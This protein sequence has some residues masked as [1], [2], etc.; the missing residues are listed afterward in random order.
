MRVLSCFYRD[1][2]FFVNTVQEVPRHIDLFIYIYFLEAERK[3]MYNHK[4]SNKCVLFTCFQEEDEWRIVGPPLSCS[5]NHQ[6]C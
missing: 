6:E 3:K 2:T 1:V 5:G 4:W